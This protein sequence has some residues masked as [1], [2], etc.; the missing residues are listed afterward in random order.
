[1]KKILICVMI[2]ALC[3]CAT[4]SSFAE[5]ETGLKP[6]GSGS[7]DVNITIDG[8]TINVYSVDVTFNN[9]V[10]VYSVGMK[11]NPDTYVYEPSSEHS[12]EGEGTVTIT[13]HSDLPV[14]YTVGSE[15]VVDTYGDLSIVFVENATQV[16]SVKGTIE[17]CNVGDTKGMHN[18]TATYTVAGTPTA[19]E[20]TTQRLGSIVVTISKSN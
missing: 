3:L 8:G 15:D 20:I 11:W 16:A 14:N 17:K 19:T 1:M 10:F 5:N 12:W 4:I 2:L 18:A 13:N 9:T 6:D 7:E